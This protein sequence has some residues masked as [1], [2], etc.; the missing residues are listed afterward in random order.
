METVL[1]ELTE[2]IAEMKGEFAI[3]DENCAKVGNKAA[4]VRARKASSSFTN[5]GKRFRKLSVEA[6]K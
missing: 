5:L 6:N 1:K 2:V 3:F 4:A